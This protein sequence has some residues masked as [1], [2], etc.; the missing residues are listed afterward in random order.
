MSPTL[1]DSV[2][3]K[4]P[5]LVVAGVACDWR[6]SDECPYM[7][8]QKANAKTATARQPVPFAIPSETDAVRSI[9]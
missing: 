4:C 2:C 5:H 3:S 8:W 7:M 6:P 1:D 9:D